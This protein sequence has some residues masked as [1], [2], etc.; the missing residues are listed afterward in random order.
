M[1]LPSLNIGDLIAKVPII[2][3][4]MGVGVSGAKLAA[5]VA[6][7][8]GIGVIS[9]VQIG[10]KEDD[11]RINNKLANIRALRR[12]IKR[13]K[14]LSPDGIIGVN[15]L[16]AMEN[17]KEMVKTAVEE[18]VNLI[19]SGAGLP[20]S[21]PELIKGSKTKIAPIVSSAKAA[22]LISKLWDRKY[23]Y[24]PDMVIVEGPK[25]GGH[26]GFSIS[27]LASIENIDLVKIINE[28]K[29][30]LNPFKDKYQKDI[31][32]VVAGG[33]FDGLDIAKYIKAGIDGVQM[34]TRF[35]ATDE[36]EAHIDFKKAYI[37]SKKDD[38]EL[39]KSPVGM[40]GRAINNEFV[41]RTKMGNIPVGKCY[42]C[43]SGCSPKNIPYCITE[44][45]V[46]AVN[47]DIE[48]GLIFSGSNAYKLDK[49]VP[50]H[51]LIKE[52]IEEATEKLNTI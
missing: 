4:G 13:A 18:K 50:V 21:L 20:K 42:N 52:L 17:Y 41:K 1:K 30:S 22:T 9:G 48:N 6:N 23:N 29:E 11:F 16:V 12:E 40:P 35:V 49:I 7:E 3:G 36:C 38:I 2:Q 44:A 19:I 10:Y 34:G 37:N 39:I 47:G 32:V 28:V 8:G 27:E 26:L 25:A 5:A 24:V 31:P 15:F 43:I 51:D 33:I 14:D 45:L 46:S